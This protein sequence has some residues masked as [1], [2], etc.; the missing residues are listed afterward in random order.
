MFPTHGAYFSHTG[1]VFHTWA[2]LLA[3]MAC[4]PHT[5]HF[6]ENSACNPHMGH[7]SQTQG[8]FL[9]HGAEFE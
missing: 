2:M 6:S 1:N 3:H 7:V 4:F 9:T 8:E 5:A